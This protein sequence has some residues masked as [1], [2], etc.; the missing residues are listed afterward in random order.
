MYINSKQLSRWYPSAGSQ[1]TLHNFPRI[2]STNNLAFQFQ[3]FQ[4]H[5]HPLYKA[6]ASQQ[7]H[8]D[9]ALQAIAQTSPSM[10]PRTSASSSSSAG[11]TGR[12]E[13]RRSGSRGLSLSARQ[14]SKLAAL[15]SG[16]SDSEDTL[17]KMVNEA[18]KAPIAKGA[19]TVTDADDASK[20]FPLMDL[21][22]EIRNEIY[23]ACLTR[24]FN[25]LLSKWEPRVTEEKAVE[26][27]D[28]EPNIE[29]RDDEDNDVYDPNLDFE[30]TRAGR[31]LRRSTAVASSEIPDPAPVPARTQ[32]NGLRG[33]A[34]R[35]ARPVRILNSRSSANN[36][37]STDTSTSAV[38][39]NY[40]SR[41]RFA[42]STF[43]IPDPSGGLREAREP[44]PQDDDPLLIALLRV[45]RQV[46]HEARSILYSENHFTLN[47]ST[48][49]PTLNALHQRSRRQIQRVELTIPCYNEI[50]ERF[51]ETVRL[52]LRY[53]WG[54]R[55]LVIY[56][57]FALPGAES[58]KGGSGNTTVYANGFDILRWLPKGCDVQMKGEV[59]KEIEA[60]VQRNAGLA[61][62]LDEVSQAR[63]HYHGGGYVAAT[64][65]ALAGA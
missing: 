29:P 62:S 3:L 23:R 11:S 49:L 64:T 19:N 44:R 21:P 55:V 27:I 6:L 52:S 33:W 1:W 56:M 50:L 22:A 20:V 17:Q 8:T 16:G 28:F 46:Y 47:L 57:P 40:L 38:G 35:T 41:P 32:P 10:A 59:G 65:A 34:E 39:V 2:E 43:T 60:V 58:G 15:S 14:K 25:I 13:K 54:L 48:A 5:Q 61:K 53:C 36:S 45:S 31:A 7:T 12:V 18:E 51:Q 63:L 9:L 42:S 26:T 37:N 4:S 30:D 24:P